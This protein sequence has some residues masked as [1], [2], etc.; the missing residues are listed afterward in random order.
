MSMTELREFE[1]SKANSDM[2]RDIGIIPVAISA[3][4]FT[5]LDDHYLAVYSR[6]ADRIS[7]LPNCD[8]A[9]NITIGRVVK[10]LRKKFN[11]QRENLTDENLHNL[12]SDEVAITVN[13]NS[14]LPNATHRAY[15][16]FTAKTDAL[17]H[18][19][20]NSNNVLVPAT[21]DEIY[22]SVYSETREALFPLLDV[23]LQVFEDLEDHTLDI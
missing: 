14:E 11:V 19:Y 20:D 23:H 10:R 13:R 7:G 17:P 2:L 3:I 12:L 8:I 9:G 4:Q 22:D 18:P 21:P 16:P 5:P 1:V 15:I 6:T